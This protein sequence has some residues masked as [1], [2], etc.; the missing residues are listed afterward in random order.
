[1]LFT[2]TFRLCGE[3]LTLPFRAVAFCLRNRR[4]R[5]Q[6]FRPVQVPGRDSEA[7]RLGYMDTVYIHESTI[8]IF[9]EASLVGLQRYAMWEARTRIFRDAGMLT[10]EE[11]AGRCA[12][13]RHAVVSYGHA[14][15]A[16]LI[17]EGVPSE[18]ARVAQ[19]LFYDVCIP[20][21][22]ESPLPYFGPTTGAQGE[23]FDEQPDESRMRDVTSGPARLGRRTHD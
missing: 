5:A 3:A 8:R 23:E 12:L 13:A 15:V 2:V 21:R 7:A 14:I 18:I 20:S 10:N 22:D 17:K 9:E 1:M 4:L 19:S 6:G 11:Y 16:L